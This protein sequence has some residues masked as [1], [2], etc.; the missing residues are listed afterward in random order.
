MDNNNLNIDELVNQIQLE[1]DNL[2]PV[3][4]TAI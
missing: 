3:E 4:E 1:V 2:Q